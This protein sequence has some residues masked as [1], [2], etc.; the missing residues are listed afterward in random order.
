M[1]TGNVLL[2]KEMNHNLVRRELL[3]VKT[4]T[5]HQLAT[6][7]G[8]SQMTVGTV[9]AD[10]MKAGEVTEGK[11]IPS[12]GGRPSNEY[13][14]KG[15]FCH[16]VILYGYQKQNRE[17]VRLVTVNL[18]G[19]CVY[20]AEQYFDDLKSDSFEALLDAAFETIPNIR[21][22]TF[23]LPGEEQDG[24][25]TINDFGGLLGREFLQY[26]REKYL[27]E[28][29]FV[30]DINGAVLG[31]CHRI[32]GKSSLENAV[33]GIYFPRIFNP[34]MGLVIHGRIYR[35]K[36]NFTGELGYLPYCGE[37]IGLDY[38]KKDL[39]HE[40]IAKLLALVIAIVAPEDMI[41]YGD[42]FESADAEDIRNRTENLLRGDFK[43][44]LEVSLDFEGDYE[45]GL[46]SIT[47]E[48]LYH[49]VFGDSAFIERN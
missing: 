27:A 28:V 5:K 7:T 9:I 11:M 22:I 10:L 41:L 4:A 45:E 1:R 3:R 34:G 48:K 32:G 37:W 15:S 30:N 35:G 39:L 26:Y 13:C 42:F 25:V 38:E 24:T 17:Y 46:K 16:G 47:L 33:A 21:L 2:V 14:Y 23:G 8:L 31:F 20:S 12:N 44:N 6:L 29:L 19:E 49:A 36:Q 18:L 40:K 43:V